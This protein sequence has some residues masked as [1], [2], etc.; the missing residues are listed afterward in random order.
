MNTVLVFRA[1]ALGD[2]IMATGVTR[3]LRKHY[4]R[5][6]IDFICSSGMEGLFRLTPWIDTAYGIRFRNLPWTI[7]P[8]KRRLLQRLNRTRYDLA[9]LLET[10]RGLASFFSKIRAR[11]RLALPAAGS[12]S[13]RHRG[14]AHTVVRHH[15]ILWD[16]GILPR[17][18][19]A[20][21]LAVPRREKERASRLL[22]DLGLDEA[23]PIVGMHPGN[24]FRQRKRARRWLASKDSRSWPEEHWCDLLLALARAS[25]GIQCV[26][27]GS[28][29][30]RAV[31][32]R[33]MRRASRIE[34]DLGLVSTAGLTDLPLAAA[35]MERF[36]VF[37]STDSGPIH[38]A[39]AV[40]TPIVG[41]Y[42]P[43]R[44]EETRPFCDE[45]TARILK[46]D[47]PCQPCYGLSLQKQCKK[48]VCMESLAV[49]EVL[50][51]IGELLQ[52]P[53]PPG[54][55]KGRP[56]PLDPAGTSGRPAEGALEERRLGDLEAR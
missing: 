52:T 39:A 43:T 36:V 24:S 45:R 31:N 35:L 32:E 18:V 37:V 15:A 22:A 48:A 42:G 8:L 10:H 21:R 49:A 5:A 16:A 14:D 27:F 1:G 12:A 17:E 38:I 46:R 7:D 29:W 44:F 53:P 26:L 50:N 55:R 9:V 11:A 33:I 34:P 6:R 56:P 2:T 54:S 19:C 23:R 25:P 41:L 28:P 30:D 40:G 20:P 4:P 47:L 13:E 3:S 51:A